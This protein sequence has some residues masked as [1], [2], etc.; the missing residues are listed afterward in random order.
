MPP[1]T[2]L[3][4]CG[5]QW[6]PVQVCLAVSMHRHVTDFKSMSPAV[7][8]QIHLLYLSVCVSTS[9]GLRESVSEDVCVFLIPGLT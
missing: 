1:D 5:S 9:L 3:F 2:C 8:V 6:V 7:C 4:L